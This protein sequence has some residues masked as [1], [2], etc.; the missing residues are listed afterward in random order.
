[1]AKSKENSPKKEAQR[2]KLSNGLNLVLADTYA[3]MALTHA[4]H[5]N[6]EGSDFFPLHEAFQEQYEELFAAADE[7][8][9]Q[10]R[11]LEAYALGGLGSFAEL[12][13]IKEPEAPMPA[14]DMV[15]A[16]AVAHQKLIDDAKVVRDQA[17]EADDTQTEDL[18]VER[19]RVHQKTLWMLKSYLK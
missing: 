5:W 19:L 4:F 8:A 9:E 6:V 3:L 16:L 17:T 12:A 1:M 18:M 11:Q 15:A 7:I 2:E 13:K 10:V 14:K